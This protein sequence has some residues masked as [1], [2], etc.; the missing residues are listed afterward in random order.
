[1]TPQRLLAQEAPGPVVTQELARGAHQHAVLDEQGALDSLVQP[2]G[3][4]ELQ[5]TA[6]EEQPAQRS[7]S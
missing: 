6:L 4:G 5:A 2:M 3:P 1:M 7:R